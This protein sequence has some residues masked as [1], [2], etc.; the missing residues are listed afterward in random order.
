VQGIDNEGALAFCV[1]VNIRPTIET[2]PLEH[3]AAAS[4]LD[5]TGRIT[6]SFFIHLSLAFYRRSPPL[7]LRFYDGSRLTKLTHCA[8]RS[9]IAYA[10]T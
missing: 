2:V 7:V 9:T 5:E 6:F 10:Y 1:L 8:N 4:A 3:A